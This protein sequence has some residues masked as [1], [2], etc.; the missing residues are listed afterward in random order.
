MLVPFLVLE[1][2]AASSRRPASA[3]MKRL[4]WVLSHRGP[5]APSGSRSSSVQV[6]TRRRPLARERRL[7]AR[8]TPVTARLR[9]GAATPPWRPLPSLPRSQKRGGGR[10]VDR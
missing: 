7:L 6:S 3:F 2:Y 5:A 8:H 9:V 10:S 1:D 4:V